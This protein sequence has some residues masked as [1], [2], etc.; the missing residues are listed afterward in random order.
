MRSELV[1]ERADRGFGAL[2]LRGEPDRLGLRA[3]A[4]LVA[5]AVRRR[6]Q[7][8]ERRALALRLAQRREMRQA[9]RA[10]AGSRLRR[11]RR[12]LE[13]LWRRPRRPSLAVVALA[14]Q[15]GVGRGQ[16]V[17][18][19]ALMLQR[20]ECALQFARARL[21]R[22]AAGR[23]RPPSCARPSSRSLI[24]ARPA[25][26]ENKQLAE[27]AVAREDRLAA[28]LQALVVEREHHME[29]FA[30]DAG[31]LRLQQASRRAA[32]RRR[33]PGCSCRA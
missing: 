22:R 14:H 20:V 7:G 25:L 21:S 28:L 11:A 10:G 2:L 9:R 31:E 24:S 18:L 8:F 13:R 1:L 23:T 19:V 4:S 3:R 12:S 32:D 29:R 30:I 27:I 26:A 33:R 6:R 15:L 17:G 16:R 5:P